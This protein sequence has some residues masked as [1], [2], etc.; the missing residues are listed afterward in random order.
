MLSLISPKVSSPLV[1]AG[2]LIFI[3]VVA[4][5]TT[6][7]HPLHGIV[8]SKSGSSGSSSSS[9]SSI[10]SSISSISSSIGIGIG[11]GSSSGSGSGGGRGW[12]SGLSHH[13]FGSPSPGSQYD[14]ADLALMETC[15]KTRWT[16]GLWL[17]CHSDCG[18][19]KT[20]ICGGLNNA[21]NRLQISTILAVDG[22]TVT[23]KW[24]LFADQP[25]KLALVESLP[26]DEK[27]IVDHAVLIKGRYFQGNLVS[28]MSS[29][30]AYARTRDQP[31]EY[32]STYIYANTM[33]WG[34][35]RYYNEPFT[36]RGD[37]HTKEF[38]IS[39]QDI[40]D[41]FP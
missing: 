23:D 19:N 6:E 29:L 24:T 41:A 21:R 7:N 9:S 16:D 11:I 3:W 17:S 34:I 33:K 31:E 5:S 2:V 20:S 32:F 35:N 30:V 12:R 10:S 13:L 37:K 25:E 28:T 40:M 14:D 8:S 4:L 36:M 22:Y 39:G 1:A 38:V 27:A 18:P 26:F 15:N